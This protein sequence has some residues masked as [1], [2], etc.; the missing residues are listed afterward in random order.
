MDVFP[1][2]DAALLERWAGAAVAALQRHRAEIDRI[3]VFPVADRDTGTN[4][5]LTMGAAEA[6]LRSGGP[7][8]EVLARG[9]LLGARGNSGVILSQVLR[10]VGEAVSVAQGSSGGTVLADALAR[11]ARL[12]EK[13][14]TRPQEGTML[15]VLAAAAD[16]AAA[17]GSDR[18]EA[19]AVAAVE[20]ATTA[21]RATP[22]QLPELARAGV[23][24]AGG[25]GL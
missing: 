20:A 8:A 1:S 17:A 3:N 13:A 9:A 7:A 4:M 22:D 6:E 16:G 2:L 11:G 19:V 21:L 23:V 15:T 24:D 14:V 18:L 5:L 25:L 10:G 12:A